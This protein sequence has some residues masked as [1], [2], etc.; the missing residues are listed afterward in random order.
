MSERG[1]Q[2]RKVLDALSKHA[3]LIAEGFE[4]AVLGGDKQRDA[5]IE[6]LY[7]MGVS[8]ASTPCFATSSPR[9]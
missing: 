1:E 2:V 8:T 3:E 7:R 9:T 4:G 5:G 6:A